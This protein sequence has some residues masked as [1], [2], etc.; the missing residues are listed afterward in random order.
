MKKTRAQA[1]TKITRSTKHPN[2]ELLCIG[3]AFQ[4]CGIPTINREQINR[5]QLTVNKLTGDNVE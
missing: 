4:L 3:C 5:R 1:I 2:K